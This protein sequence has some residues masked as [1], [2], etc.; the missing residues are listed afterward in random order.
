M[1]ARRVKVLPRPLEAQGMLKGINVR[2]RGW[3]RTE[4]SRRPCGDCERSYGP[5]FKGCAH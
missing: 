5:W 2:P 1:K 4:A 3:D